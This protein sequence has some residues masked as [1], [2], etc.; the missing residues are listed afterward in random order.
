MSA[1]P[2]QI[3]PPNAVQVFNGTASTSFS[4]ST[5]DTYLA[6]AQ[7]PPNPLPTSTTQLLAPGNSIL[8]TPPL[9]VTGS[10]V[11]QIGVLWSPVGGSLPQVWNQITLPS[12]GTSICLCQAADGS[13]SWQRGSIC[14]SR[15]A[16]ASATP[17]TAKGGCRGGN[18]G[19]A[20]GMRRLQESAGDAVAYDDWPKW[21][22]ALLWVGVSLVGLLIIIAIVMGCK[23]RSRRGSSSGSPFEESF[24]GS[25]GEALGPGDM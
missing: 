14:S 6:P 22:Q 1:S 12:G 15:G 10:Y 16:V 8:V 13:L 20:Q 24:S 25:G 19:S 5:F 18:C 4:V 7:G 9:S 17:M 23:R 3:V 21:A 2:P 11:P